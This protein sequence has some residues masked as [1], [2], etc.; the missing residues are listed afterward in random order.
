MAYSI[1][2][3]VARR[4]K[5]ILSRKIKIIQVALQTIWIEDDVWRSYV[6]VDIALFMYLLEDVQNTSKLLQAL[7]FVAIYGYFT[8]RYLPS[9][10]NLLSETFSPAY[11]IT[12]RFGRKIEFSRSKILNTSC[13]RCTDVT[14]GSIA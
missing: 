3:V 2:E 1:T 12:W 6:T 14:E 11:S 5:A 4:I 7:G 10:L 9:A 8:T 13:V